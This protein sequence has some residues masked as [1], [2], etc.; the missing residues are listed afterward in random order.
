MTEVFLVN[1][2][3]MGADKFQ[4]FRATHSLASAT[5]MA[6]GAREAGVERKRNSRGAVSI[7]A[8]SEKHAS[9]LGGVCI[10]FEAARCLI[11]SP[12][13]GGSAS[14]VGGIGLCRIV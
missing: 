4:C 9:R 10:V 2:K 12:T 8:R 6:K 5:E 1:I 3:M 13:M 14:D 7:L 11:S